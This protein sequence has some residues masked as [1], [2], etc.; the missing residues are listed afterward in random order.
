MRLTDMTIRSLKT[1]DAGAAIFNDDLIPGF[2][3]RVSEGGTKSFVLTHGPRRQRETIGRVGVVSLQDARTAAKQRLAEYTLGKD[4]PRVVSWNEAKEEYL[5]DKLSTLKPRTHADYTY[6]LNRHFKY[7]RTKLTE[8]SPHDLRMSLNRLK[9]TPAEQQHAFVIVRAFLRWAHR[10]H[11]LDRN[12]LER[13]QEPYTYIPRERILTN[14]EL[15]CVW[16]AARDDTFGKIVKLLI[17]TGQRRGEIT[18]L[19]GAM[20]REDTIT[21]PAWLAKNSRQHTFPLGRMA[22]DTSAK[23]GR[24]GALAARYGIQQG[25]DTL[26]LDRAKDG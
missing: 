26:D 15:K 20:V 5:E 11:Y 17:L 21:L 12:P 1:P 4:R 16:H 19:T 6:I 22:D 9:A 3:V 18:Q 10:Q 14:D 7:A 8:L 13:M 25:A 24:P 23:R 2:G